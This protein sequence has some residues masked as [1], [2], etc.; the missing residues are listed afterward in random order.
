MA[1]LP[2]VASLPRLGLEIE[3]TSE[4]PFLRLGERKIG[5]R[6]DIVEG[7]SYSIKF[8]FKNLEQ[9]IFPSGKATME[10][11]WNSGQLVR[12]PLNI[13]ELKPEE[14]QYANFAGGNTI[15]HSEALSSGFGLLYCTLVTGG[16]N[17]TSLNGEASYSVSHLHTAAVRSL[18][19]TTWETIYGQYSTFIAAGALG[20]IALQII[21]Q[22][23]SWLLSLLPAAP[24]HC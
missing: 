19:A 11:I 13:P 10:I 9:T 22:F 4:A 24:R 12:W 16:R 6:K 18:K 20:I 8:K 7:E 17:L 14:E 15:E 1:S 3:I 2:A 5:T 23:L 21:V